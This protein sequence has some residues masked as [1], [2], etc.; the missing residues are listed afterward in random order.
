MS[1]RE[2]GKRRARYTAEFKQEA[3]RLVKA[4]QD[5]GVAGRT[6]GVPKQTLTSWVSLAEQ[7]ALRG[8]GQR[9]VVSPSRWSWRG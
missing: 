1:G 9:V 3:V 2:A 6:L 4:G 5:M 8:A 7:G